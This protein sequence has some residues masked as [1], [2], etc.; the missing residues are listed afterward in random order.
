MVM[1]NTLLIH[2]SGD[3]IYV[4][5]YDEDGRLVSEQFIEEGILSVEKTGPLKVS[6]YFFSGGALIVSECGEQ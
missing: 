5:E 2:V 4:G 6:R 3:R 1:G